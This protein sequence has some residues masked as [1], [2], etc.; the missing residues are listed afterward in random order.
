[1]KISIIGAGSIGLL[2]AASINSAFSVTLYTRTSQQA[3]EINHHGLILKKGLNQTRIDV[4]ALPFSEWAGTKEELTIIA[5]KQYQLN[6]ILSKMN[7]LKITLRNLLFIQNGMG[8]LKLLE[9]LKANNIFLGSVEHGAQKENA[10]TVR[11]NGGGDIN[12]AVF[13]GEAGILQQF[14]ALVPSDFSLSFRDDYYKMLENKLIV[15]AVI[16]PLTALLQVENGELIRNKYYFDSLRNL[17]T[18]ISFILNLND[19]DEQFNNIINICNKTANNRSSMLKDLD[20]K[21]MTENEAILGFLLDEANKQKKK[22]PLI[23]SYFYL[24]KGKEM[25]WRGY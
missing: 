13:R 5:V 1:M 15:N 14:A 25:D 23:E 19:V 22:A 2:F 12:V 21:R 7:E 20:N 6:S 18:E 11:H 3:R 4:H 17:F 10:F 8:H 9:N 16:N 24:L